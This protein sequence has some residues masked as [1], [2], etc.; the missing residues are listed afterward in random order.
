MKTIL[1][2]LMSIFMVA[3]GKTE[4]SECDFPTATVQ[5]V[6]ADKRPVILVIGDSISLGYTPVLQ[7]D[8]PNYNVVHSP[9][10]P[11][12]VVDVNQHI[13]NWLNLDAHY[14]AVVF[15]S[16]LHDL[17]YRYNTSDADYEINLKSIAQHIKA[18]NLNA[19]F[20]LSTEVLPGT[21]AFDASRVV[22]LNA[23]GSTVMSQVGIPVFDLYSVSQTIPGD[24]KTPTDV[25]Y[26]GQGYKV[27]GTAIEGEL[28]TLFGIN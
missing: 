23:I 16:G 27:L 2:I 7:S 18:K 3:C 1:L 17:T 20:N 21:P 5:A 10:N 14:A 19:M 28:S 15:N 6:K 13:D 8:L 22:Q 9:C 26:T 24:H 25:H 11:P 4:W 12:T